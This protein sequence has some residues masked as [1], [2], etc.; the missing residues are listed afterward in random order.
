MASQST[1]TNPKRYSQVYWLIIFITTFIIFLFTSCNTPQ[2]IAKMQRKYC[3]TTSDSL[4]KAVA[5]H[6]S[7]VYITTDPISFGLET[8]CDTLVRIDT[9]FKKNGIKEEIK[10]NYKHLVFTCKDDSLK[11]VIEGLNTS[12]TKKET[13]VVTEKCALKHHSGWDSFC[14]WFTVIVLSSL[15]LFFGIKAL[16]T[17]K[18]I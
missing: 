2:H 15:G 3:P 11:Q 1:L 5:K 8:P 14:N 6:D 10:G 16:K 18:V 7:I 9:V 4:S 12:I 13:K 17:Y